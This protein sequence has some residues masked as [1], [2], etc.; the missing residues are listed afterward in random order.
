[1]KYCIK[2]EQVSRDLLTS[3]RIRHTLS[4]LTLP[5]MGVEEQADPAAVPVYIVWH[6]GLHKLFDRGLVCDWNAPLATDTDEE[7]Q[8]VHLKNRDGSIATAA[9]DPA[10]IFAVTIN[11]WDGREEYKAVLLDIAR[12]ILAPVVR[13]NIKIYVPHGDPRRPSTDSSCFHVWIWSSALYGYHYTPPDAMW[14]IPTTCRDSMDLA[15]WMEGDPIVT[16]EG[17][18]IG[19]YNQANA[20]LY[21]GAVE[22]YTPNGVLLLERIFQAIAAGL[23]GEG[24]E[25][26]MDVICDQYVKACSQRANRL[27]DGAKTELGH[28]HSQLEE[29]RRM[30]HQ[31]TVAI[32]ECQKILASHEQFETELQERLRVEFEGM[33]RIPMVD[34]VMWRRNNLCV[35]TKDLFCIDPRDGAERHVGRMRIMIDQNTSSLVF[36]NLTHRIKGYQDDMNAPHVFAD[37]RPCLGS[38]NETVGALMGSYEWSALI[39]VCIAFLESVNTEDAAGRHVH[40]WPLSRTAEEVRANAPRRVK[41]EET[42]EPAEASAA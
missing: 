11:S 25:T 26:P 23:S 28:H 20:Y 4:E 9:T 30:I 8:F 14:G 7:L 34:R 33:G 27:I 35:T 18:E 13:K 39:Q 32:T 15:P 10:D 2:Q 29:A 42:P 17:D 12:R 19:A 22:T 38:L 31:S 3:L 24:D 16:E 6:T 5:V 21:F 40:K 41:I 1:M 37:G 36:H